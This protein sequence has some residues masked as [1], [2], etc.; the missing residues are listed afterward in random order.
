MSYWDTSTLIKLYIKEPDFA[1]FEQHVEESQKA[2]IPVIV[3]SRIALFEAR[4]TF[5]RKEAEQVLAAGGAEVLFGEILQDVNTGLIKLVDFGADIESEYGRVLS[6]CFQQNPPIFL[7][8]LDA[9]HLASAKAASEKELVATDKRMRE[10]A[11]KLGFTLF[12]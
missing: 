10:A 5:H 2:G 7:R 8:T 1:R 6:F 4:A 11:S 9:I 3:I 12:P